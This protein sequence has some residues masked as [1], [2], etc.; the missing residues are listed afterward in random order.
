MI[1]DPV[2]PV[3]GFQTKIYSWAGILKEWVN[4]KIFVLVLV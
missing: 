3:M 1:A 2:S 4:N